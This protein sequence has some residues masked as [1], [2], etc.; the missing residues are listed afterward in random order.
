MRTKKSKILKSSEAG[1]TLIEVLIYI[2]LMGFIIGGSLAA[3]Y[4]LLEG[5]RSM[6]S[7]TVAEQEAD[8]IVRKIAWALN[9]AT[10]INS[11]TPSSPSGTVLSVDKL[12][13][14]NPVVINLIDGQVHLKRG[15]AAAL[16]INGEQVVV[17]SLS[18]DFSRVGASSDSITASF[19]I[20]NKKF[21]ITRHVKF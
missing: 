14:S 15:S 13:F 2:L 18:F 11:P 17:S 21:Q 6:S 7:K 12:G 3:V 20:N 1:T 9:G 10:A 5:S 4:Q 19:Y 8:F 16:P